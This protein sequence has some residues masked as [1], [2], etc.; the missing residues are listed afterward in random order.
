MNET[1]NPTDLLPFQTQETKEALAFLMAEYSALR[2]ELLKR[3]EIQHQ[4]ITFALIAS[5]TFLTIGLK[6]Q[7]SPTIILMYPILAMF[8]SAAWAQSDLR[9][10]QIGTYIKRRIEEK[11]L[12]NH[13]GWEHVHAIGRVRWFGSLSRF[14][15]GGILVGSQ[16]LAIFGALLAFLKEGYLTESWNILFLIAILDGLV[17]IFT[18]LL[19]RRHKQNPDIIEQFRNQILD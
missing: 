3:I 9:I 4:L 12:G 17:I 1:Q 10:W 5:G 8:L 16:I 18:F 14:A 15:S 6:D 7:G 2:A 13:L 19:L 11:I